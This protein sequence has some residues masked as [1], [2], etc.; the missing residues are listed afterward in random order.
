MYVLIFGFTSR[1]PWKLSILQNQWPY[2]VPEVIFIMIYILSVV[3][4]LAVGIMLS[5]HLWGIACGE[6]SV[7]SQDHEIYR[8]RAKSR[9]EVCTYNVFSCPFLILISL[10]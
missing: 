3:L 1:L 6:T 5:Y 4:C 10:S 2:I 9:Q 8:K 7:E